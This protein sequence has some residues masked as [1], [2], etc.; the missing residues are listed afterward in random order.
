MGF[1]LAIVVLLVM[2]MELLEKSKSDHSKA[3]HLFSY[4]NILQ[5]D[6]IV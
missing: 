3:N 1:P 6:R 4:H 2:L 5:E